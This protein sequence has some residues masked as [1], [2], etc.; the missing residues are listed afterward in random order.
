MDTIVKLQQYA[1]GT[2]EPL[3]SVIKEMPEEEVWQ[4][5]HDFWTRQAALETQNDELRKV[6]AELAAMA[7]RYRDL[8]E[9]APVGYCILDQD[10]FI[11]E[12]NAAFAEQIRCAPAA[13]V[14]T[15]F[16]EYLR[17]EETPLFA[18]YLRQVFTT[19]R[20]QAG[21]FSITAAGRAQF[22]AIR[23]E[24]LMIPHGMAAEQLCRTTIIDLTEIRQAE[25]QWRATHG[26]LEN[27]VK[28]QTAELSQA[29]QQLQQTTA[30]RERIGQ[31]L[32]A[33]EDQYRILAE[34]V[35]DGI[36]ILQDGR[37][38]FVNKAMAAIF[39]VLETAL[40]GID[41]A[42]LVSE[43]DRARFHA[44]V[45]QAQCNP[46]AQRFQIAARARDNRELWL[47]G[48]LRGIDWEGQPGM[49]LTFRDVT[50]RTRQE[51]LIVQEKTRLQRELTTLK[52]AMKDRYKFGDIIGKSQI[53]QAMYE[54]I[55]KAA[56]NDANVFVYGE[57]GTGKELIARTIHK[58]SKRR[59]QRFIPV[60]CGAIPE[61]LF[62]SEFFGHRKGAFTGAYRDKEGFFSVAHKGT[63]F[64][65]ELG[66]LT[67]PMQVKL[68]RVLDDGEYTPLGHT[69]VKKVDVRIIA[70]TNRNLDDLR[71]RGLIREDFFFRIHVFTITV[72]PLRERKDDIPLLLE[73]FLRHYAADDALTP[74]PADIL[75]RFYNYDWPGNV[76]EFQN[77]L[78]RYLSGQPLNFL[79]SRP[80]KTTAP[81]RRIITPAQPEAA[82]FDEIMED[83]E[84]KLILNVLEQHH[85]NKSK[86]ATAL[87]IPRRTLYR[88]MEKYGII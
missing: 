65:D 56:A 36:A 34:N 16:E 30:E 51:H 63:L 48:D 8:Y 47:D 31:A 11:R 32:Q 12:V 81:L 42:T 27:L 4:L 23:L 62:E 13:A 22:I 38:A 87:A 68:L 17:P 26:F 85:W 28:H 59:D 73:H 58:M 86:T 88:K 84:K 25:A 19:G 18:A 3:A 15:R 77:A 43:P 37:I 66:E 1:Q 82:E 40:Q 55:V 35:A 67:P 24:S 74:L 39:G 21:D 79:N 72:P 80:A 61:T 60:N 50:E 53:M 71:K 20:R 46:A 45:T 14:N 49:L 41:P 54:Q 5:L 44:L 29:T 76:R 57:S 6:N 7:A 69:S 9:H 78:Q 83:F 70:A 64:L 33:S 52:S 2:R 75:E 10:G